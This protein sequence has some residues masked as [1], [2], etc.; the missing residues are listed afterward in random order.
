[1]RETI[2]GVI[3]GRIVS[4]GV[5]RLPILL[6]LLFVSACTGAED[7]QTG[8]IVGDLTVDDAGAWPSDPWQV[9]VEASAPDG[10]TATIV[11]TPENLDRISFHIAAMPV[12]PGTKVTVFLRDKDAHA[13]TLGARIVLVEYGAVEVI[14]GETR[15]PEKQLIFNDVF[16]MSYQEIQTQ[17]FSPLCASC[18]FAGSDMEVELDNE[19]SYDTLVNVP[20]TG[21]GAIA[22]VTPGDPEGS[23]LI[24][25]L[26]EGGTHYGRVSRGQLGLLSQWIEAGASNEK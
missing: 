3:E 1:M 22:R 18:H 9:L 5:F 13:G 8:D 14:E 20:S 6:T 23:Y 4:T 26:S 12:G 11:L 25:V 2:N 17:L 7:E 19:S 15:L 10:A 16:A 24:T 21:D